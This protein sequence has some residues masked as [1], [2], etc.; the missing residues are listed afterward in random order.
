[1][2][3]L[4]IFALAVA[5]LAILACGGGAGE[6]LGFGSSKTWNVHAVNSG[7]EGVNIL[8]GN[9]AADAATNGVPPGGIKTL[10]PLAMS[11]D[12]PFDQKT[13]QYTVM[14]NGTVLATQDFSL[15]GADTELPED[16]IIVTW[17]GATLDIHRAANP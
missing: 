5:L 9:E 10:I 16:W 17:D 2:K 8:Q 15:S 3:S 11:F 12:N 4:R 7:N 14:R 13:V 1:M 6:V